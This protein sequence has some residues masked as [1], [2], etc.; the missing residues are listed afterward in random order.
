M[1]NAPPKRDEFQRLCA[2]LKQ[3]TKD[4]NDRA[5]FVVRNQIDHLLDDANEET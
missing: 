3:A 2:L 4:G 5:A 1:I